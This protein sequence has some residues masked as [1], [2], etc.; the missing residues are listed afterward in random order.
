MADGAKIPW[1]PEQILQQELLEMKNGENVNTRSK[2][3]KRRTKSPKLGITILHSS[4]A[5]TLI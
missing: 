3:G 1:Q 5:R 2:H 4:A